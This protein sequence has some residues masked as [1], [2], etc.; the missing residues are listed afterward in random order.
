MSFLDPISIPLGRLMLFIY[1]TVAFKNYGFALIIFTVITRLAMLPLT[2]K[3][4][5]GTAKMQQ[6]NPK[7]EE[8][9]RQYGTDKKRLQEETMKLYQE[10][11][12]NPAG[13]C[14]PLLIQFPI[15]F[16]LYPVVTRPLRYMFGYAQ[17]K[18][19]ALY[20]LYSSL[21]GVDVRAIQEMKMLEFFKTDAAAMAKAVADDLLKATDFLNMRFFGLDLSRTPTYAPEM[22]FGEQMAIYLPLMLIPIIGVVS[23]YVSGK[24][25]M[26]SSAAQS[27]QNQQAASM[28]KSMQFI[29]PI[30]T[31]VF[32]FQLPASVLIYWIAGYL[33]QIVQQ[34]FINKYVLKIGNIFTGK[35]AADGA[36]GNKTQG[37]IAGTPDHGKMTG[38]QDKLVLASADASAQGKRAGAAAA[39]ASAS[40]GAGGSA[41]TNAAAGAGASA[42]AGG[43]QA[44]AKI[45]AG[46]GKSGAIREI[47]AGESTVTAITGGMTGSGQNTMYS[48]EST[49][50]KMF[51]LSGLTGGPVKA[52]G[53]EGFVHGGTF[54]A[55]ANIPGVTDS[56]FADYGEEGDAGDTG[57]EGGAAGGDGGHILREDGSAGGNESASAGA[58]A[59]GVSGVNSATGGAP[60]E[61][62]R[63]PR[64]ADLRTNTQKNY[65]SKKRHKK[66]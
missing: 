57:E 12:V 52:A 7:L 35:G 30:M 41:G 26:A 17:A 34:L 49:I 63:T 13:G 31:L 20:A 44:N 62:G 8:L 11:K 43:S 47:P 29:G 66:K 59:S 19:D 24:I 2:I 1:N 53:A 51:G 10:E 25:S 32:S 21:T 36:A 4:Y 9:R 56:Y 58:Y 65:G 61:P 28:N 50:S 5:Q 6:L 38:A 54:R 15:L 39:G 33:I 64:G 48:G 23:T 14:L 16:A 60:H 45:A 42:G 18:L 40:A 55:R 27:A 46:P 22:L 37:K 3:Q